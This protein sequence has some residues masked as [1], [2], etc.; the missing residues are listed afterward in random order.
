MSYTLDCHGKTWPDALAE[1]IARYNGILQ[2][3]RAGASLNIIHGYGSTGAGGTMRVR[4]RAFLARYPNHLEYQPGE[5]VDGNQGHTLV[6]PARLLPE[7]A[8][9]LAEQIWQYCDRPRALS[10]I[11]GKFR[12]HGDAQVRQAIRA[13]E[14][15]RRLRPAG[16]GRVKTYQAI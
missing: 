1:F 11:T 4:F 15:Q 7:T 10:K 16:G 13:L 3:G 9:L 5:E 14:R 6:R 8:D 2:E 12:R